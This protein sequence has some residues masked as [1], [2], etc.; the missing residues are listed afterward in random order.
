MP[1]VGVIIV[2]PQLDFCS[3]AGSLYVPFG[4]ECIVEINKLRS[5]LNS[6]DVKH[7]YISKDWHPRD[8]VSFAD[9]NN[10]ALFSEIQVGGRTQVMWPRHCVQDTHGA[11]ISPNLFTTQNDIIIHK[12]TRSDTDSYS[13]FGSE[14]G[15]SEI[16]PLFIHLQNDAITHLVIVGLA[17]DFCVCST[18]K[19]AHDYGFE[20]AVC[21]SATGCVNDSGF[22]KERDNMLAKGIKIIA[23]IEGVCGWVRS[24]NL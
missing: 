10:A 22:L 9:N 17:F 2:D 19:D 24:L 8:H 11:E 20:T 6:L 14:D 21:V 18:A 13:A 16:T 5:A 23:D 4:E 12:G 1:K 3:K 15:K 7:Y